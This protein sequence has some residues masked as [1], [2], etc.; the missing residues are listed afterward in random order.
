[1]DEEREDE[2]KREELGRRAT[3]GS[4]D[5]E[6]IGKAEREARRIEGEERGRRD[7]EKQVQRLLDVIHGQAEVFVRSGALWRSGD[8]TPYCP[9]CWAEGENRAPLRLADGAYTCTRCRETWPAR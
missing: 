5:M 8:S 3:K 1:M 4:R 2:K 7:R 9:A 6:A